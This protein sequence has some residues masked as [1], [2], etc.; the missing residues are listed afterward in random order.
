MDK[1]QNERDFRTDQLANSGLRIVNFIVESAVIA[2][3]Y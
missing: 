2:I 1:I 3:I